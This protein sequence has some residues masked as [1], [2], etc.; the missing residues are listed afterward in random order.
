MK[1]IPRHETLKEF[2]HLLKELAHGK[3]APGIYPVIVADDSISVIHGGEWD[4]WDGNLEIAIRLSDLKMT[5]SQFRKAWPII[6]ERQDLIFLLAR[7]VLWSRRDWF[8]D[9]V[10]KLDGSVYRAA[11]NNS[12]ARHTGLYLYAPDEAD[13]GWKISL[14]VHI[15]EVAMM[16]DEA[17]QEL[18]KEGEEA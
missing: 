7:A 4:G 11:V 3:Y 10:S 17:M 8:E 16:F 6:R 12:A 14:V 2:G 15:S 9:F 1:S 5:R 18:A 13:R